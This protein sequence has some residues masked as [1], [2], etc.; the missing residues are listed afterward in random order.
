MQIMQMTNV[1]FFTK[2]VKENKIT[3]QDADSPL[4]SP[5]EK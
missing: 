3:A 1:F 4:W 5:S 2:A